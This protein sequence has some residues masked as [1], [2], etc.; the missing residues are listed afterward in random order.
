ML[1]PSSGGAYACDLSIKDLSRVQEAV[2]DARAKWYNIGLKLDIDPGTLDTI[3]GNSDNIDDRFR[4]MLTTWLKMINPRPT[5]GA[6]A[7]ALRSPTVGYERLA[8][9]CVMP[10]KH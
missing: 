3:K 10:P 2:W 9:R 6:L 7:K 5:W 1:P 4:A 8:E